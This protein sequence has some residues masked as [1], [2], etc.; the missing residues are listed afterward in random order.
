MDGDG[1]VTA[2]CRRDF[3]AVGFLVFYNED[4]G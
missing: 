2:P 3:T 1:R 4:D